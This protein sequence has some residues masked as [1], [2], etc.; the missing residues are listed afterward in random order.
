MLF[1]VIKV[2]I[3]RKPVCDFLLVINANCHPIL[4]SF[5][6]NAASFT[7]QI[8]DTLRFSAPLRGQRTMY[9]VHLGLNGK[10]VMDFLLMLIELFR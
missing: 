10:H 1:K 8:W 2:G 4:Y 3:N 9:D 7:V 5:G 6:V